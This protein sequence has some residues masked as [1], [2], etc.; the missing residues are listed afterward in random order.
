MRPDML[1]LS[2]AQHAVVEKCGNQTWLPA[3]ASQSELPGVQ[4]LRCTCTLCSWDCTGLSQV[5]LLWAAALSMA[6]LHE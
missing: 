2:A 6:M 4:A 1:M 3:G 5:A